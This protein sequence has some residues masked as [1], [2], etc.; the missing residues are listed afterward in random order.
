VSS[1]ITTIVDATDHCLWLAPCQKFDEDEIKTVRLTILLCLA[2]EGE[3]KF[4]DKVKNTKQMAHGRMSRYLSSVD[5]TWHDGSRV[6][7]SSDAP[8]ESSLNEE[9]VNLV[10]SPPGM[11]QEHQG[12][13][14]RKR[15]RTRGNDRGEEN[16]APSSTLD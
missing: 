2:Y 1:Q 10:R 16:E 3:W 13:S 4:R 9:L 7:R 12:P 11:D 14:G 6:S 8:S 15:A 5:S